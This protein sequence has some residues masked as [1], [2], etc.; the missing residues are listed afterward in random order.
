MLR[1]FVG[2]DTFV[3]TGWQ[4]RVLRDEGVVNIDLTE[5]RGTEELRELGVS[6]PII[7]AGLRT[8]FPLLSQFLWKST[9][10]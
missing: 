4:G 7:P 2:E 8:F 9:T 6:A 5:A 10:P 1:Y 3:S